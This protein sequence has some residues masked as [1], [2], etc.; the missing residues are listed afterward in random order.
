MPFILLR[1]L[2]RSRHAANYRRRWSERFGYIP[3]A[4][5]KSIWVHAVSVGE[6]IAAIPLIKALLLKYSDYTIVVTTTTPTGSSLVSTHF[7]NQVMHVYAPF[8]VPTAVRRF[9]YRAK[10]RLC[11]IMETELW[12]N[13]F[14]TCKKWN[15]PIILA[16]GRLSEH[17][18]LRYRFIATLTKK[19]LSGCRLVIAQ[20]VLDGERYLRLGLDPKKLVVSGNIKFDIK[21]PEMLTT[22]ARVMKQAI[23]NRYIF[24]AASTHEKEENIILQ[25]FR[26][27]Q[28]KIP[29]TLLM[30]AP[31]HSNRFQKVV[32]LCR[33]HQF[34]VQ[35]KTQNLSISDDTDILLIDTIGDLLLIY[36]LSD[37]AFVGGSLVSVG[38]H[39]LIEPAALG[40]PILS[41]PYLDNF[42]DIG[43]L[44]K[45]AG[46]LQIVSSAN[47]LADVAIALYTA[48]ELR[49]KIGKCAKAVI[50][51]NRGSLEKHVTYIEQQLHAV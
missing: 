41:G 22:Q 17:S 30:L 50:D 39:N 19:M 36:A 21:I 26:Q 7:Q 25:A 9:L 2:W 8:D 24:V 43:N 10:A 47:Q 40:V 34:T 20:G 51:Q 11:I 15:V 46:A 42:L 35:C 49:E 29:N 3:T 31:R 16:N 28:R 37:I 1:L 13:L 5:K 44:L 45:D 32:A 33:T 4:E 48:Q 14:L 12:P 38:G 23:S 27:I 18:S 6:A